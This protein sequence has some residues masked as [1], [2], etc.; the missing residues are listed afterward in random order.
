M[1][2]ILWIIIGGL[3]GWAASKIMRGGGQG[4]LMNII[5]GIVGAVIGGALL[6]LF[7]LGGSGLIGSFVTALIGA[8]VLLWIVD[9]IRGRRTV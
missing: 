3:A 2:F 9:L 1:G 5:I 7:G 8:I 4:I 6:G